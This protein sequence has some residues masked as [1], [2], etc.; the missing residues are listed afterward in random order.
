MARWTVKE[1]VLVH[2]EEG[3][4][5]LLNVADGMY[6]ALNR[7]GAV[8]WEALNDGSDPV[9]AVASAWPDVPLDAV[10]ADVQQVLDDLTEAG[11]ARR[12][13]DPAPP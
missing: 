7:T 1:D 12:R 11:L 13:D 6:Y 3:E 8:V 5:L 2:D 9:E 4:A 10:R